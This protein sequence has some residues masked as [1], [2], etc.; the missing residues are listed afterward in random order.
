MAETCVFTSKVQQLLAVVEASGFELQKD[1]K[2]SGGCS[3]REERACARAQ[4]ERELERE[5]EPKVATLGLLLLC[6]VRA[7]PLSLYAT[8][9]ALP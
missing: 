8:R 7:L 2:V 9:S 6:P 5:T 3:A 4:G 1:G